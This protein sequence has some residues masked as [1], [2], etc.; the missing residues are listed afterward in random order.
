MNVKAVLI[1][2]AND[3]DSVGVIIAYLAGAATA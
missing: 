3:S 1:K 2:I